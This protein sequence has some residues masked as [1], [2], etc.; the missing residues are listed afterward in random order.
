MFLIITIVFVK[1][2][3]ARS[4]VKIPWNGS[5]YTILGA[6]HCEEPNTGA[7]AQFPGFMIEDDG[8]SPYIVRKLTNSSGKTF[9]VFTDHPQQPM[10]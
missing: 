4:V 8:S 10:V 6:N 1:I 5:E 9:Y 2:W 7:A 3:G